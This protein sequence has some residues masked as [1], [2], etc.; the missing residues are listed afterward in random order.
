[1]LKLQDIEFNIS[2][3][4]EDLSVRELNIDS[5]SNSIDNF[6]SGNI[7]DVDSIRTLLENERTNIN[8][9]TLTEEEKEALLNE[10]EEEETELDNLGS[11]DI[12]QTLKEKIISSFES[13]NSLILIPRGQKKTQLEQTLEEISNLTTSEA[14]EA[15]KEELEQKSKTKIKE[16]NIEEAAQEL[17]DALQSGEDSEDADIQALLDEL[18]KKDPIGLRKNIYDRIKNNSVKTIDA[19]CSEYAKI[20]I[21]ETSKYFSTGVMG[22]FVHTPIVGASASIFSSAVKNFNEATNKIKNSVQSFLFLDQAKGLADGISELI[23]NAQINSIGMGTKASLFGSRPYVI[24][25]KT[26]NTSDFNHIKIIITVAASAAYILLR[27]GGLL[28]MNAKSQK[29]WDNIIGIIGA[30]DGND[31]FAALLAAGIKVSLLTTLTKVHEANS[32]GIGL[33]IPFGP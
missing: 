32:T 26:N 13:E 2:I 27:L 8:N 6:L 16:E 17:V 31:L 12:R 7:S 4:I 29:L 9:S 20:V 33:L 19:D 21:E 22:A 25:A 10:I 28:S 3:Q 18:R 5:V 15:Y 1:M 11:Q 23:T 30:K 14:A 24:N